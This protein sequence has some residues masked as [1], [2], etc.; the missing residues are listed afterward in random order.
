MRRAPERALLIIGRSWPNSSISS[1]SRAWIG[2]NSTPNMTQPNMMQLT[3]WRPISCS[4]VRGDDRAS[5]DLAAV[6]QPIRLSHPLQ[7]KMFNQ[8]ADFSGLGEADHFHELG[9]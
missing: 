1:G 3:R 4:P 2:L 8:H 6:E 5:V 9:Y 7:R